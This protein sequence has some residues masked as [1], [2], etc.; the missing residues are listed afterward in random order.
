MQRF[1]SSGLAVAVDDGPICCAI[2]RAIAEAKASRRLLD[3]RIVPTSDTAA[4][5]AAFAD[6][7]TSAVSE[8]DEVRSQLDCSSR[9]A[10]N[11]PI[12]TPRHDLAC[13]ATVLS[14]AHQGCE[15]VPERYVKFSPLY[16]DLKAG[17]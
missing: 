16:T 2:V 8:Q 15:R 11:V 3:V 1:I 12:A 10:C 13:M 4:S 5:E 17:S 14:N 9:G 7:A 6:L